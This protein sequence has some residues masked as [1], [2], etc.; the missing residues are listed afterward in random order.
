MRKR[1]S[2]FLSDTARK[3]HTLTERINEETLRRAEG[4]HND[5]AEAEK[6]RQTTRDTPSRREL[7]FFE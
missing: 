3:L 5:R 6:G 4:S 2:T 1:I 7:K